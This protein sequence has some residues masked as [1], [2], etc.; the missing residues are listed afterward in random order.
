MD[1]KIG[2]RMHGWMECSVR[3]DSNDDEKG[4]GCG[5]VCVERE[6]GGFRGHKDIHLHPMCTPAQ[7]RLVHIRAENTSIQ[8]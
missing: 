2:W 4:N 5:S 6:G 8:N 7:I 3:K 1:T